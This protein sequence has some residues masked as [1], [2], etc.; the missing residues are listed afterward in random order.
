MIWVATENG[1]N[2]F[3]GS[4]FQT[5]YHDPANPHSIAHNYVTG[6]FEDSAGH[7]FIMTYGGLQLYRPETDDF[8]TLAKTK[9]GKEY[10]SQV[11]YIVEMADKSLIFAGNEVGRIDFKGGS[12]VLDPSYFSTPLHFSTFMVKDSGESLWLSKLGKGVGRISKNGSVKFYKVGDGLDPSS[13]FVDNNNE[14]ITATSDGSLFKYDGSKDSFTVLRDRAWGGSPIRCMVKNS[15]DSFLAGTDGS[16]IKVIRPDGSSYDFEFGDAMIESSTLKVH[17]IIRDKY[18]N[19][20]IA[21]YQKGVIM[22][23]AL[24]NKFFYLGPDVAMLDKIGH[25]SITALCRGKG[26]IMWVGTD[27]GGVYGI[28]PSSYKTRH[29]SPS[30]SENG[31]PSTILRLYEDSKG[32]LWFGSYADGMG[33]IDKVTGRCTKYVLFSQLGR[34]VSHIPAIEEDDSGRLWIGSMGAGLF[35]YDVKTG[36][37]FQAAADVTPFI[38]CLFFSSRG[39]M[40]AATYNGIRC[41][42]PDHEDKVTTVTSS[43]IVHTITESNDGKIWFGCDEGVKVYDPASRKITELAIPER[44]RCCSI[45]GIEQDEAGNMWFGTDNGL[46]LYNIKSSSFTAYKAGDGI[47][48]NEFSKNTCWK[49]KNGTLWFGGTNG[50]TYFRPSEIISPNR[51]WHVRLTDIL[52]HGKP[53]IKGMKSGRYNIIDRPVYQTEDVYLSHK[54]NAFSLQFSTMEYNAPGTIELLS[55]VNG[56]EW[57]AL[58][59]NRLA[60]RNLNPGTYKIQV[61]V[62]DGDVESAPVSVTFHVAA[63]WWEM[64]WAYL[65]YLTTFS[66]VI[67]NIYRSRIKKEQIKSLMEEYKREEEEKEKKLSLFANF[68]H[69]LRSP[70]TL[71]INPLK[72]LIQTDGDKERQKDYLSMYRNSERILMMTNQLLDMRKIDAGKLILSF[73]KTDVITLINNVCDRYSEL[74]RHKNLSMS[75]SHPGLDSLDLWVDPANFDKV[76]DNVISNACKFTPENGSIEISLEEKDKNA[77]ITVS[78]SGIGIRPGE[79]EKIFERFY[80]STEGQKVYRGGTGIGLDLARS[81]TELHHGDIHAENNTGRPGSRF[82]IRIPTGN[83]H[84]SPEEMDNSEDLLLT[85]AEPFAP[86]TPAPA[87]EEPA[88]SRSS[89]RVM[90]VDDDDEVREFI[91]REL[92]PGYHILQASNGRQAID[93]IFKKAPDLLISDIA[94]PEMDG[95]TLCNEIKS[96]I[97][98]NHIPVI[99]LTGKADSSDN[100]IGLREGADAYLTKPFNMEILKA[101][102]ENLIKNR[103]MLQVKFEGQQMREDKLKEIMTTTPDDRLMNRIMKVLNANISNPDLTMES[104]ALEIGISR[105]HLYRKLKELTNQSA[106]TFIRNARLTQAAKLFRKGKQ[107][108]N[109]VAFLVGFKN[110]N[111]FSSAFKELYG[112]SPTEYIINHKE[113]Q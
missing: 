26:G 89:Y 101:T 87:E 38:S 60:F 77:Y 32:T 34:R 79:T 3:D 24:Y 39:M 113:Q 56:G 68:A 54:D 81:I 93:M 5:Y 42:D 82:I 96:N 76:I 67:Y 14:V 85:P 47:Q 80:Q 25:H 108:V 92:A 107:S 11:N 28:E 97:N 17:D 100:I 103:R 58:N 111:H 31:V 66:I 63:P 7:L 90:V 95:I 83:A 20:W 50:L 15:N 46:Y 21:A 86:A 104:L 70:L 61:K 73:R 19:L 109:E 4:K 102:V 99:L 57:S 8:S 35:R 41:F 49:D 33:K 18:N 16:G 69:E 59:G 52:L 51:V 84:L 75:F 1:L 72:R 22:I 78:D 48:G 29:F 9:D 55:S 106:S 71:I 10:H 23:P 40:Y 12:P 36:Q 45:F 13:I 53:V 110:P 74:V 27:N 62:R 37:L 98:L 6:L 112:E 64:W 43:G 30:A 88:R 91:A 65:I 105:V 44:L 94:M 2:R